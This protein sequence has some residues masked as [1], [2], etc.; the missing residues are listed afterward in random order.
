MV[1]QHNMQAVNANRQLNIITGAQGKSTEKLSSGYKINRAADDAAGLSISEKMRKQIRGLDRASTNAQDGVSAVQ[2]AEGALGEVHDMLQRMNELAVQSANGTNSE[3]D[4]DAIQAEIDQLATEIDRVSETTKFNETYLLKGDR[5]A[6]RQVSYSFRNNSTDEVTAAS[7]NMY[8]DGATGIAA[9]SKDLEGTGISFNKDAKQDDQNAIAKAL[10]DQGISVTYSSV[11]ADPTDGSETGSIS[12]GYTLT[13]NGDAADKYDVVTITGGTDPSTP[14]KDDNVGKNLA[15]FMIQDHNGN[16]IATITVGGAMMEDANQTEKTKSISSILTAES[17]TAAK[18]SG[19]IAQYFDK[20][21]NK[22]S[23]NS[24]GTYFSVVSGQVNQAD[25]GDVESTTTLTV[26]EGTAT[27]DDTLTFD[28]TNWKNLAGETISNDDLSSRYGISASDVEGAVENDVINYKAT[29]KSDGNSEAVQETLDEKTGANVDISKSNREKLNGIAAE[30]TEAGTTTL[31]FDGENW[32]SAG[33]L[34]FTTDELDEKAGLSVE[35]NALKGDSIEITAYK[36]PE[37]EDV[38]IASSTAANSLNVA[39][40]RDDIGTISESCAGA[41]TTPAGASEKLT[42]S[43]DSVSGFTVSDGAFTTPATSADEIIE[44]LGIDKANLKD[45][46]TIEI[47]AAQAAITTGTINSVINA[48]SSV[49]SSAGSTVEVNG[50]SYILATSAGTLDGII[51]AASAAGGMTAAGSGDII[52]IGNDSYKFDGTSWYTYDGTDTSGSAITDMDDKIAAASQTGTITIKDAS[53]N[54]KA[55]H[56]GSAAAI[57]NVVTNASLKNGDSVKITNKSLNDASYKQE[58]TFTL[59]SETDAEARIYH[60]AEDA[61]ADYKSSTDTVK[62]SYNGTD[63][64]DDDGNAVNLDDYGITT[65]STPVNGDSIEITPYARDEDEITLTNAQVSV[66]AGKLEGATADEDNKVIIKNDGGSWTVTSGSGLDNNAITSIVGALEQT[67]AA[68]GT[69]IELNLPDASRLAAAKAVN[70]A[71]DGSQVTVTTMD[72]NGLKTDDTYIKSSD[73]NLSSLASDLGLDSLEGVSIQ[74]EDDTYTYTHDDGGDHWVKT[75]PG[76]TVASETGVAMTTVLGAA[77]GDK[78]FTVT[79]GNKSWN[80]GTADAINKKLDALDGADVKLTVDKE[81][82]DLGT[83]KGSS[84]VTASIVTETAASQEYKN[85]GD[86]GVGATFTHFDESKIKARADSPLVYDAVGNQTTLDIRDVSAKRDIAGALTV[87]LHVGADATSNNQI[88][89][90][91]ESMS[92]KALGVNGLKVDGSDDS[93][94]TDAIE[95]I[96]QALQKVSD[97]RSSLGAAQNRLEHTIANLDNVVENT[98]A[99]ES[100]IRDTDIAEEMVRYS[101]NNILAQA[102]QSMLAQ[103]NQSTQGALSLLG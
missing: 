49:D 39:M 99:A 102:G 19:E 56:I 66:I 33:G 67:E 20:D 35:G 85:A 41:F 15:A 74:I 76:T 92:A 44:Y 2:T 4:R 88:S 61:T 1:V 86:V 83:L 37:T 69:S 57:Q 25:G 26:A 38:E 68:E 103:A 89:V 46:D 73:A 24:L 12:N 98:E 95:T 18:G 63:W 13:L 82:T 65:T 94:A 8:S 3:T 22:I 93:N 5:N 75:A 29:V 23:A 30:D 32:K 54:N 81:T 27:A 10:R 52:E 48:I 80:V 71:K 21:G 14:N 97:Q 100:R 6:T 101:K 51:A 17:V 43:Y 90:N 72:A 11:Y 79:K 58:Q 7:A 70:Q 28:G 55:Y 84:K 96:K 31:T 53:N 64:T 34:S 77:I 40:K 9:N 60:V 91:I 36:A 62:L 78:T 47:T 42:I 50:E 45:G 59:R 16:T 87:K